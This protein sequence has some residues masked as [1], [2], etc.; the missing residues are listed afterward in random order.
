M[1]I[2]DVSQLQ[3]LDARQV[4][5]AKR[6]SFGRRGFSVTAADALF[7]F[8]GPGMQVGVMRVLLSA[9]FMA[10]TPAAIHSL[11]EA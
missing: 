6:K 1:V 8:F 5:Q 4:S 3:Q 2:L 7:H 10:A 11:S 9:S